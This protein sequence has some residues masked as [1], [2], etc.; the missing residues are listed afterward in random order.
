MSDS[1]RRPDRGST[2]PPSA[3]V[4]EAAVS[5][6]AAD[7]APEDEPKTADEPSLLERAGAALA[8]SPKKD[9]CHCGGTLVPHGDANPFKAGASHCD[10]CGCCLRD[11]EIRDG[12][13]GC[14]AATLAE[15]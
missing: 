4:V 13:R 10:R 8:G 9:R 2:P 3:D 12:H 7:A 11:G 5:S 1:P 6:L 14:T 15:A